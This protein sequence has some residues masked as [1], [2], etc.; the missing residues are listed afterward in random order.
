MKIV[1]TGARTVDQGHDVH[2][3]RLT[4]KLLAKFAKNLP[5]LLESIASESEKITVT[6]KFG[7]EVTIDQMELASV[8]EARL[9]RPIKSSKKA[10]KHLNKPRNKLYNYNRVYQ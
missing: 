3:T 6:N 9:F 5:S 2:G 7:E 8:I 1:E 4:A 10:N